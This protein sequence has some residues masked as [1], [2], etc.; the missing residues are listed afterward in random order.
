MNH[1]VKKVL[2]TQDEY[3]RLLASTKPSNADV[4]LQQINANMIKDKI[5]K[6]NNEAQA[7]K[8]LDEQIQSLTPIK[9]QTVNAQ[10]SLSQSVNLPPPPPPAPPSTPPPTQPPSPNQSSASQPSPSQSPARPSQSQ[11]PTHQ[12]DMLSFLQENTNKT[13]RPKVLK[14]YNL[15]RQ[16]PSVRVTKDK[17]FVDDQVLP[18]A[19]TLEVMK[20]LVGRAANLKYSTINPLL[21]VLSDENVKGIVQNKQALTM[22]AKPPA[23]PLKTSTP[24]PQP[25]R[26]KSKMKTDAESDVF[27]SQ[28]EKE[29]STD[30][31]SDT[32]DGNDADDD[33]DDDDEYGEPN[34]RDE[35]GYGKII[36]RPRWVT[37]WN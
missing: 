1:S 27:F 21:E 7:L 13:N 2:L 36:K 23:A 9:T 26:Q 15:L 10:P 30:D 35:K 25:R 29:W 14:L 16:N 4:R 8:K 31:D 22:L 28:D 17:I 37:F 11:P 32:L 20:H 5:I 34:M 18:N 12:Q 19:P 33:D 3:Q 6:K 24:K